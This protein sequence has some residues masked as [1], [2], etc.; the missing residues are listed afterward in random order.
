VLPADGLNTGCFQWLQPQNGSDGATGQSPN[1][2]RNHLTVR[3]DYQINT[4]NKV[5]FTMTREKD[6]GVTGQTGLA[7]VPAGGFGQIYRPRTFTQ[8]NTRRLFLPRSL[9]NSV[10]VET[11]YMAR[12]LSS[13]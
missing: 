13:R 10:G 2:N 1:T 4:K 3:Y 5:T 9:T 12:H 8:S 7:D 11:G 6:W